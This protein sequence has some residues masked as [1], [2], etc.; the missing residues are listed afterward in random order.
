LLEN[1]VAALRGRSSYLKP[2]CLYP[3]A[4]QYQFAIG[5]IQLFSHGRFKMKFVRDG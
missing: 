2:S 1:V 3:A 4:L 5:V